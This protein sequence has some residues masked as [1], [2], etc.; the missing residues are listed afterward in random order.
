MHLQ[1]QETV[2]SYHRQIDKDSMRPDHRTPE[3]LCPEELPGKTTDNPVS[4]CEYQQKAGLSHQQFSASGKNHCGSLQMSV[5]SRTLFQ[6]DQAAS[7]DQG[8]LWYHLKCCQDSDL[9][10]NFH[11][12]SGSYHQEG[13]ETGSKSL[14]Y[15]T[16]FERL[17]F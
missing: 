16:G 15:F 10:R 9:D 7:E 8:I 4:R 3:F 17:A 12:C 13:S 5:A 11:L 14:H 2:L 1:L 6:M